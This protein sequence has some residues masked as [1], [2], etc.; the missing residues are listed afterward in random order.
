VGNDNSPALNLLGIGASAVES[1]A[2]F[3]VEFR[4]D[5]QVNRPLKHGFTGWITRLGGV[6]AGPVPLVL[7]LIATA[8]GSRSLRRA[9]AWSSIAGS[10]FTR[11]GWIYAGHE[12]AR[13][14]RIPLE[15][16]QTPSTP[17]LASK[18]DIPQMRAG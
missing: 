16:K 5:P 6:L 12:S 2:G 17:E 15:I 10:I 11:V 9:A 1:Y 13:D 7:R 4:G 8:S 3:H 14:W 18:P